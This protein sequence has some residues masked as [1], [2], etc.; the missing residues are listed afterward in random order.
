MMNSELVKNVVRKYVSLFGVRPSHVV[1]SPGRINVIGEHTD[2][3]MGF[4]LPGAIDKSIYLAIGPSSDQTHHFFAM[5]KNESVEI[6]PEKLEKQDANWSD[7]LIGGL[8]YYQEKWE[9]PAPMNLVFSSDLPIGAGLS[10]SS[11]LSCGMLYSI[12]LMAEN[13]VER[14]IIALL[15]HR[16]EREFVGLKGGIMDQYA[17]MLSHENEVILIDCQNRTTTRHKISMSDHSFVLIDTRVE[18]ELTGSDY[19]TRA[20]ESIMAVEGFRRDHPDISSLRDVTMDMIK[21]ADGR[22]S[23]LLLRRSRFVVEEN[24][25]VQR[26]IDALQKQDLNR[27]GQLLFESHNG[28]KNDYEV[29]CPELDFL[30]DEAKKINGVL[31]SRMMGGGFGGCT[32]NLVENDQI[33]L[34]VNRIK[35][36]YLDK[37]D[38]EAN[39]IIVRLSNGTSSIEAE[40]F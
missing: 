33:D 24:E 20:E 18:H 5:D 6:D 21:S 31:G 2:Y 30:V 10:S 35:S 3:N 12:V 15:G 17:N 22:I 4:V 1:R 40:Y 38:I 16:V 14:E 11:A 39:A 8:L 36:A 25:R 23:E 27:L 37:Y 29:S 19:N 7:Y 28:L 34:L 26:S 32:I 13:K 9:Q